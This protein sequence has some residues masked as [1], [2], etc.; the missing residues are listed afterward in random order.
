M[1]GLQNDIK[2][3]KE[4]YEE[5]LIKNYSD[6]IIYE[7]GNGFE[8]MLWKDLDLLEIN[9]SFVLDYF[10]KRVVPLGYYLYMSDKNEQVMDGGQRVLSERHYLKP[11]L[12][13]NSKGLENTHYGNL[14]LENAIKSSESKLLK[15]VSGRYPGQ[16][17]KGFH[18]LIALLL[19]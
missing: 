16:S 17:H 5:Y 4:V 11:T 7:K 3:L 14:T 1:N 8:A 10:R 9:A 12:N 18:Q 6:Y 19:N 2:C 15:I 13:I